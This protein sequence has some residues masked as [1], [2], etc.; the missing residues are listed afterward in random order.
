MLNDFRLKVFYTCAIKG[1]FTKAAKELGI[2]QPAVSSHIAEIE[3]EI[4]D[5]LFIRKRGE[6]VLTDKGNILYEYAEKIM[7]LY[8]CAHR[9]LVPKS[10]EKRKSLRIAAPSAVARTLM[11]PLIHNYTKIYSGANIS[12]VE[13]DDEEIEELLRDDAIDMAITYT[14]SKKRETSIFAHVYIHGASNPM[15]TVYLVKDKSNRKKELID[16]FI[17]CCKTMK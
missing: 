13:K 2:T 3:N 7:H 11:Q 1:N 9:E 15:A 12:L 14:P 6:V 17:L 16:D 5:T 8:A 4:G 10:G